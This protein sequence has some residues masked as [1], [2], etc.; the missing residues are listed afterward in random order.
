[1]ADLNVPLTDPLKAWVDAQAQTGKFDSPAD[2]V[3]ALIERDRAEA[4]A[5]LQQ[6]ITEGI[7]SGPS[8]EFDIETF[9][10]K[11]RARHANGV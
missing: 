9:L 6:A 2:Y 1:M 4:I 11:M 3:R 10:A 5:D 7:E 8:V